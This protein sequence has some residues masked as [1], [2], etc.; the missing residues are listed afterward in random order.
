MHTLGNIIWLVLGGLL[1]AVMY[2][3]AGIIMCCTIIGIPF[4]S[5]LIKFGLFTFWPFG[6][7]V[8]M[9]PASGCL[10]TIFNILWVALGWWEIAVVHFFFGIILCI[11]II[12]IPFG[13]QH[14]KLARL[15]LVPFGCKFE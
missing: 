10:T 4:G 14:F 6:K 15:S 3:L 1:S 11:S 9:D 7:K 13:K 2:I 12:G 8:T 5:Q